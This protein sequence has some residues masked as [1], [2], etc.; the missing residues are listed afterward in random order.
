MTAPLDI[1]E[2]ERRKEGVAFEALVQ[3]RRDDLVALID[4]ALRLRGVESELLDAKK[5][6]L[7]FTAK[8]GVSCGAGDVG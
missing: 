1:D 3:I 7:A 6:P 8:N 4:E 2:L 5:G